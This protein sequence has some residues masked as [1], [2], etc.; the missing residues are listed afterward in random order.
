MEENET[1]QA[2]LS[3]LE[4]LK[5]GERF[6]FWLCTDAESNQT[7]FL[8]QSLA[9][10]PTMKILSAQAEKTALPS[11]S[12]PIHG[13]GFANMDGTLSLGSALLA[14]NHL[15]SIASWV[16]KDVEGHP[17]LARF[18][19]LKLL[20]INSEGVL[21]NI[22]EYAVLWTDID[23][24]QVSGT[25]ADT[26]DHMDKMAVDKTYWFW[27]TTVGPGGKPFLYVQSMKKD[28][29]GAGFAKKV[30]S[31]QKLTATEGKEVKGQV[32]KTGSDTFIFMTS[33]S[34]EDGKEILS[35]LIENDAFNPYLFDAYLLKAGENAFG[36]VVVMDL[37]QEI[38]TVGG[39]FSEIKAKSKSKYSVATTTINIID[40]TEIGEKRLFWFGDVNGKGTLL[41]GET[42]DGLKALMS[43]KGAGPVGVKGKVVLSK[44]GIFEFY[45]R[46]AFENFVPKLAKWVYKN[47]GSHPALL[48][49]K[50]SR[51]I[52]RNSE[53]EVIDK[54]KNDKVWTKI[55]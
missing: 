12:I 53:G 32:Q 42:K 27:M 5:I 46:N 49:L 2:M 29:N 11:G 30:S 15:V 54:Q 55:Q 7:M 37:D 44:K 52:Q 34:V 16:N 31:F 20:E 45:S 36:N 47:H 40:S 14:A 1:T 28:P 10:D 19:N 22:Y 9:S 21:N 13:V 33:N 43:E 48:K 26:I 39:G 25:M 18:K 23:A 3:N 38:D 4:S 17:V 50:G 51:F 41:L 8:L 35:V 24:P 6:W